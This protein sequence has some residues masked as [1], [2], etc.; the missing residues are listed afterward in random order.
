MSFG[1]LFFAAPAALFALG[2]L[3]ILFWLLRATPPAPVRAIFPPLRLL[4]GLTTE[5][6][7]RARAPLW[8]VILRGLIA[9]ALDC[10]LCRAQLA[11]AK[12]SQDRGRLSSACDR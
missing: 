7:T 8:L 6:E 5:E 1:P 12:R 4:L 3:P 2:A 11:P 9:A 10:R